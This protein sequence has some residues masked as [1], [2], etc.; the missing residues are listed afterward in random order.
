M[1]EN[2]TAHLGC[3]VYRSVR[4]T[5]SRQLPTWKVRDSD[6]PSG[7]GSGNGGNE[8]V[9]ETV[10]GIDVAKVNIL[11]LAYRSS[12]TSDNFLVLRGSRICPR[13]RNY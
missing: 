6:N 13:R 8:K 5:S 9:G 11:R 12:D 7:Y 3:F 10:C 2:G 1:V 4:T